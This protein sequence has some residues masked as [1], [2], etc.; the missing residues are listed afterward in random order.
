MRGRFSLLR[1]SKIM[2]SFSYQGSI[3][4]KQKSGPFLP[5]YFS[6]KAPL[7]YNLPRL[8]ILPQPDKPRMS[9]VTIRRPFGEL[10]LGDQLDIEKT[11][12][13]RQSGA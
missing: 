4:V 13:G 7:P 3:T 10:D 6:R 1:P 9:Q 8:F 11:Y 2:P 12:E 5:D